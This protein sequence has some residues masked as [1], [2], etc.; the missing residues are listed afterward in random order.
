MGKFHAWRGREYTLWH[1]DTL[2]H[3]LTHTLTH[4]HTRAHRGR[5]VAREELEREQEQH[6]VGMLGEEKFTGQKPMNSVDWMDWKT[7]P[8]SKWVS[9]RIRDYYPVDDPSFHPFHPLP[10]IHLLHLLHPHHLW[11]LFPLL[12]FLSIYLDG[13]MYRYIFFF[14]TVPNI[15]I[16]LLI[17][18]MLF[19]DDSLTASWRHWIGD[20]ENLDV[21]LM[22][23]RNWLDPFLGRNL[24]NISTE[25]SSGWQLFMERFPQHPITPASARLWAGIKSTWNFQI[26]QHRRFI[27]SW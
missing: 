3:T 15:F 1:S 22:F 26:H 23:G 8:S 17:T 16:G 21:S 10:L 12:L 25:R 9:N 20:A 19:S 6:G 27:G 14:S 18:P 11:T 13:C 5:C 2:W 7:Y 24:S 4:T